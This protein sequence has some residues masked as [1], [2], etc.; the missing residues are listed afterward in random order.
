MLIVVDKEHFS[1]VILMRLITGQ[2]RGQSN[3]SHVT[4]F[5]HIS[6]STYDRS[7]FNVT[8]NGSAVWSL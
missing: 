5:S 2:Q 1:N 3:I 7:A 8:A 4:E 6:L